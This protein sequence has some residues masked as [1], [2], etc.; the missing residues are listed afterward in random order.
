MPINSHITTSQNLLESYL[1]SD[2]FTIESV[3]LAFGNQFD[4]LGLQDLA[5]QFSLGDFSALPTVSIKSQSDLGGANGVYVSE[6]NQIFLAQEFVDNGSDEQIVAVILEEYGHS[7]D[8]MINSSDS[9][10]DEGFIFSALVRGET[11]TDQELAL[12]K[13]ENDTV[14]VIIDGQTYQAEGNFIQVTNTNDSGAGS[15]RN[16]LSS[17][18]SG[19]TITFADS[20]ANGTITLTSGELEVNKSVTIDGDDDNITISGNNASRVFNINDGD[21]SVFQEVNISDLTITEGRTSNFGFGG[22]I[23]NRENLTLT[24]STVWS[25]SATEGGGIFNAISSKASITNSTISSNSAGYGGGGIFNSESTVSIANSTISSNSARYGGGIYNALLSRIDISSTIISGNNANNRSEIANSLFV[26]EG[27]LMMS[28]INSNGNNLFGDSSKSNNEAF[29][30]LTPGASDITATSD[31]TNPTDLANILDPAGLQDNGGS[32]KTIA[33]VADSPAIDAGNNDEGLLTDQRGIDRTLGFGT[34][35]GA[36]EAPAPIR[37]NIEVDTTDD[38]IA[39]D[40]VISLR[41]AL[42]AISNGGTITFADSIANGTITLGGTELVIDKSVTIDGDDD[43][44]TVS[45]N[46]ASRVF[47]IDDGDDDVLQEVNISDLTI[48]SGSTSQNG[49]GIL[50]R[51]NLTLT[52]STLSSNRALYRRRSL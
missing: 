22:G 21:N 25:N 19:G 51:E 46:N 44:I 37:L 35:I 38:T 3:S 9:R 14:E 42:N 48:T 33:L 29:N 13:A 49:G 12:A 24:D 45:G 18:A 43:N 6:L 36:F 31:G 11:L 47:K 27:N 34:D 28:E 5:Q 26:F 30:N 15:L 41:E 17:I 52:D 39:N 20:I 40:G 16:A 2:G 4:T 7:I 23:Y 50:N 32:T 8:R 10:G 1:N